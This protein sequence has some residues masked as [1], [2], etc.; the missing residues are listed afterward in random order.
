[1]EITRKESEVLLDALK[2]MKRAKLE[3]L[4][5]LRIVKNDIVNE[6]HIAEA[7]HLQQ[8]TE[9]LVSDLYTLDRLI[10]AVETGDILH[11]NRRT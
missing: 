7:T 10:E 2:S 5:Q 3:N 1:M 8:T 4:K 9:Q 11:I 6:S